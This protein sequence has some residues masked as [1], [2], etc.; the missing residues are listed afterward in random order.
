[1]VYVNAGRIPS[2]FLV[3]VGLGLQVLLDE[4]SPVEGIRLAHTSNDNVWYGAGRKRTAPEEVP[5][6]SG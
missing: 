5:F 3:P 4:F 1:M 6:R 2:L